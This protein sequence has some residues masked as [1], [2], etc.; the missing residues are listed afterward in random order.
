M[1]PLPA[2]CD[3]L[4]EDDAFKYWP[5]LFKDKWVSFDDDFSILTK[6][7]KAMPCKGRRGKG[8]KGKGK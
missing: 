8:K 1:H 3:R 6:G 2:P 7:I 4:K 5:N